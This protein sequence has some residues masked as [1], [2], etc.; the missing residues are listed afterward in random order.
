[1]TGATTVAGSGHVIVITKVN[2]VVV[3]TAVSPDKFTYVRPSLSSFSPHKG[4]QSG[5]T[6]LTVVGTALNAGTSVIVRIGSTVCKV[7]KRQERRI[8]CM[9]EP[10]PTAKVLASL[11]L[12]IDNFKTMSDANQ[13]F[14]YDTDPQIFN[15][16]TDR[17]ITSGGLA[18]YVSGDK[19]DLL[20]DPKMIIRSRGYNETRADCQILSAT[21][22]KCLTPPL[23]LLIGQMEAKNV[24]DCDFGFLLDGVKIYWNLSEWDSFPYR[25][26][27]FFPDPTFHPFPKI[28]QNG[29]Q[30]L[31]KVYRTDQITIE[32]RF[33]FF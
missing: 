2:D 21:R 4:P 24:I 14:Y 13:Q 15:I 6:L 17:T 29:D 7:T 18:V 33:R 19:F 32:V 12:Q 16:S 22:L 30:K 11:Q 8:L 5:G 10:S 3:Y 26:F 20:Q 25:S 1:M 9:T 31:R 27:R 23:P 28:G